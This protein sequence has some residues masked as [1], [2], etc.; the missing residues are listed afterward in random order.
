MGLKPLFVCLFLSL[1]ALSTIAPA[2]AQQNFDAVQ[3]ETVPVSGNVYMLIGAGG[4]VGVSIGEDGTFIIDDQFAPLTDKIKAAIAAITPNPVRFVINTHW[5]GDHTGGNENMGAGGALIVAH[6]NVYQRMSTEQF[7]AANNAT[8]PPAP[9]AALP[10][11]TFA[12]DVTFHLNGD[13]I[14]GIHVAQAHTDG[15][16]I[17]HFPGAN[18][19]HMGDTFFAGRFPYVDLGSGGSV[20][21]VISAA[22]R[23]LSIANEETK[24]IPGH[25]P[26]ST[27]ADLREYLEMLTR[28]RSA[29]MLLVAEGK[30]LEEVQAAKPAADY[31]SWGTGFIN[32]ERFVETLFTDL[33]S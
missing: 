1:I 9:R 5:H 11:V 16:A 13:A 18:V 31:E 24:I 33:S 29:V 22:N 26:L 28:V 27:P 20:D 14:R 23:A 7:R 30:T 2:A 10:I 21:G 6:D 3:I 25:G 4:N 12:E 15:D 8:T 32:T 17:I 19:I